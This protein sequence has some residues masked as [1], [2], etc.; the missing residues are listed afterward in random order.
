[1]NKPFYKNTFSLATQLLTPVAAAAAA[2]V[3]P[4]LTPW[5]KNCEIARKV[6]VGVNGEAIQSTRLTDLSNE[7]LVRVCIWQQGQID[8]LSTR[9]R[10]LEQKTMTFGG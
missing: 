4:E 1:M 8:D 10:K 9:I 2:S 6:M 7:S 5:Q 3:P